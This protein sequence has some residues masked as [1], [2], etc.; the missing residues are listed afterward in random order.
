MSIQSLIILGDLL[1]LY[2]SF[3]SSL[4]NTWLF[5]HDRNSTKLDDVSLSNYAAFL[6]DLFLLIHALELVKISKWAIWGNDHKSFLAK[7]FKLLGN[8]IIRSFN[9]FCKIKPQVTVLI[10]LII[11]SILNDG[12][13]SHSSLSFISFSGQTLAHDIF[14]LPGDIICSFDRKITLLV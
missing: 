9:L 6:S 1:A 4:V 10:N 5:Y 8:T 11:V 2:V 13:C 12:Q 14:T 7:I 3:P